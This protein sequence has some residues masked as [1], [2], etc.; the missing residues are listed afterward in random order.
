MKKKVPK[1]FYLFFSDFSLAGSTFVFFAFAA[2]GTVS[3]LDDEPMIGFGIVLYILA[4]VALFVFINRVDS[5]KRLFLYGVYVTGI[6]TKVSIISMKMSNCDCRVHFKYTI[7]GEE[8]SSSAMQS[9]GLNEISNYDRNKKI[10]VLVH[11]KY[12]GIT[13]V[14]DSLTRTVLFFSFIRSILPFRKTEPSK[15]TKEKENLPK[16]DID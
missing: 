10:S 1:F 7:N 2:S 12:P 13:F 8:R 9:I 3:I 5:L 15:R 16:K 14:Q 6:V 4:F 11:P